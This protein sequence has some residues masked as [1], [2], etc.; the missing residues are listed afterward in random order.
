MPLNTEYIWEAFHTPLH[1]FIRKRVAD[2]MVAEDLLQEVFLKIHQNGDSLQDVKKLES[3]IYQITRNAIIDFYRA[4]RPMSSLD[5]PEVL[6]LPEGLPDDDIVS[7]LLPCVRA[8]VSNLPEQDRQALVLTEYQGL[9]QKEF[10]ERI[11]L[12]F[13]GAKSRV[14][15]AREKLKQQLLACCHFELDRRGHVMNYQSR[16]QCCASE[17]CN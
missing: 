7:E 15:R 11:G 1:G 4:T 3:W 2:E 8:M 9:T 6:D 16:C 17:T 5:T 14:Q 10:G 12:S 13:S